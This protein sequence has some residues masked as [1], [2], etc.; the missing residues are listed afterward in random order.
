MSKAVRSTVFHSK[1][2]LI[3]INLGIED[4]FNRL[5]YVLNLTSMYKLLIIFVREGLTYNQSN[6]D[7]SS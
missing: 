7:F 2:E 1:L 5:S 3:T 4:L 6:E